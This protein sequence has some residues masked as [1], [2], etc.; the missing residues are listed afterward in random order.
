[1]LK[2]QATYK[3][4]HF[5]FYVIGFRFCFSSITTTK[6]T[7]HDGRTEHTTTMHDRL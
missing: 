3:N 7:N 6:N 2:I 1:M 5:F 4:S